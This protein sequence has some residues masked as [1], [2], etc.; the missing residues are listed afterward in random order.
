[1]KH[2]SSRH[3]SARHAQRGVTLI[4]ALIMLVIIALTSVSVM[5]GSLNTD[6]MANNSRMQITASKAADIALRYCET[7]VDAVVG[8]GTAPSY[9]VTAAV[10]AASATW[11]TKSNWTGTKIKT[12]AASDLSSSTSTALTTKPQCMAEAINDFAGT[13]VYVVTA[14]GFSPDYSSTSGSEVW[15][16]TI[17]K[18]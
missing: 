14:R 18:Y 12:L 11:Q 2:T 6:V 10:A 5:R 7:Q 4:V 3:P 15:V 9:V 17:R 8:G 13:T 1:M 16:Q